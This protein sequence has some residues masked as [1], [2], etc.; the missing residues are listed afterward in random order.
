MK[1]AD[2]KIMIDNK[3]FEIT[4]EFKYISTEKYVSSKIELS[5][6]AFDKLKDI[7][8]ARS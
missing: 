6:V 8:R 5:W 7:L 2:P 1:M 4:K 3:Y